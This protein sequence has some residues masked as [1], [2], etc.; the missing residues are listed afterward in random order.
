MKVIYIR[1]ST[2]EQTPELQLNA[3]IEMCG[4][5]YNLIKEQQSAFLDFKERNEFNILK[6]MIQKKKVTDLYIWDLDRLYR[7]R[8]KLIDFFEFC[9]IYNCKIHSHRQQWLEE[10]NTMPSPWNE[11]IHNLMLQVM[12]WLAEEESSKKSERVKNAIKHKK[13][14][15]GQEVTMS[16]YGNKW[17]RKGLTP[18][19]VSK[20]IE[21]KAKG[22]SIRN[23]CKE[24]WLYD[25]NG[26]KK[27]NISIGA[28]HKIL[29]TKDIE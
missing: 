12:G 22:Y 17:G 6:D 26:N 7:N 16:A 5:D 4:P 24:V 28:V 29:A 13:N 3:C 21:L 18:Q 2:T 15:K 27:K 8:K 25:D 19:S 10:V 20:V 14:Y 11:I 1:T 23:I 9:K